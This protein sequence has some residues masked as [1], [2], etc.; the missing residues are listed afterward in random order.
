MDEELRTTA[1]S[2]VQENLNL[3]TEVQV[4]SCRTCKLRCNLYLSISGQGICF[5]N[6]FLVENLEGEPSMTTPVINLT[7]SQPVSTTIQAPLPTSTSI[8]TAI[9]TTTSLS[10]PPPQP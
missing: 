4:I 10:L 5:T 3:P 8:V 9:T 6:Q 1:L 7:L 2:S